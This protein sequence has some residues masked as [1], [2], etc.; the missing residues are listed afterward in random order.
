MVELV[1]TVVIVGVLAAFAIPK[2]IVADT[3]SRIAAVNA[4]AGAIT[5]AAALTYA[6][7][8]STAATSGCNTTVSSWLGTIN[9]NPYWLNY[10][11]PDAGDVLG[12]GQ[13]DSQIDYTGFQVT[14]VSSSE[15]LFYRADAPTPADCSVAYYDGYNTPPKY[16]FVVT[17]S[18]C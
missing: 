14:L 12:G 15:T 13:I 7:C 10:G 6:L 5:D 2:F 9:G 4:L 8:M 17:T 18:G 3:Q 16:H 1:V 11:W